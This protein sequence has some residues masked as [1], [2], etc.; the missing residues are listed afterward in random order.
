MIEDPKNGR[1][2]VV[3]DT[4]KGRT[5][6]Q[7][8]VKICAG[9]SYDWSRLETND[10]LDDDWGPILGAWEGW[11]ADPDVRFK[12]SSGGAAT[13]LSEF[14]ITSG[15]VDGIAHTAASASDPRLNSTV[16]SHSREE[17]MRGVGSRYSQASPAEALGKMF[18]NRQNLGF[19]GKPC[20][21]AS[22]WK[23][24]DEFGL[25]DRVPLMI[26]IFCA[27]AP[28]L[29]ATRDLLKELQVPKG[30]KLVNLTYRGNGWPGKMRAAWQDEFGRHHKSKSISY[31][32]GWGGILQS[33]RRWRCRVCADHT[34]AFADI[35]V[36]DPWHSPPT[37]DTEAGR[38]LI[39]A[40]TPA[41]VR[42]I[43]AAI[44]AGVL[45]AEQRPRRVIEDAQPNLKTALGAVWGRT[46][47]MRTVGLA[48]PKTQ[49]QK[50]FR[51]WMRATSKHKLQSLAGTW[52]R[53]LRE[54]LRRPVRISIDP[55]ENV[56]SK[57]PSAQ[58]AAERAA[59]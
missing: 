17:L 26:A 25:K 56:V 55:T 50:L 49:G 3:E 58:L 32:L 14:A 48:A 4:D 6:S 36:G 19:V 8:A 23:A 2:P 40:R 39:I 35:S 22:I 42:L 13:A 57:R 16:I 51:N 34:G 44:N 9:A 20:D 30:A 37:N 27:G 53:I 15:L 45:V 11:A 12:G 21:V 1:R 46:Y 31:S 43:E 38:S 24:K 59:Q 5:A 54:K 41:G 10:D 7:A 29:H 28:N 18:T 47:A 33:G 52:R